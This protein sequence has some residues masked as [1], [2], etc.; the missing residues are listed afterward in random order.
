MS[1]N[2]LF[3]AIK[4]LTLC[5]LLTL[6]Q[7]SAVYAQPEPA[8][9]QSTDRGFCEPYSVDAVGY[10]NLAVQLHKEGLYQQAVSEYKKAI[11]ADS[12]MEEAWS[13][14]GSLYEFLEKYP[15]AVEAYKKS[16]A[17]NKE[18]LG[19]NKHNIAISR[20]F[21]LSHLAALYCTKL[22][23]SEAEPLYKEALAINEKRDLGG[24]YL[25]MVRDYAALLRKTKRMKEAE[26]LETELSPIEQKNKKD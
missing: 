9:Q 8:K 5:L 11:E 24:A 20:F 25:D 10:Y 19:S 4:L 6:C 1:T 23:Y 17:L 12:R 7:R 13:N 2:V 21:S 14:L 18:N 16:L 26:K 22:D 3:G 15:Q